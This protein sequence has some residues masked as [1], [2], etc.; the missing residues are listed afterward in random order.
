MVR[1]TVRCIQMI[2]PYPTDP[3]LYRLEVVEVEAASGH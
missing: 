3:N 2:F 1:I